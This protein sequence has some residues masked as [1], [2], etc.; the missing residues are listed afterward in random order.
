MIQDIKTLRVHYRR[1]DSNY[2]RWGLHLW[3]G[4]GIDTARLPA[5]RG[6]RQRGTRRCRS[7]P[8]RATPPTRTRSSSRCPCSTRRTT[9]PARTSAS[10]STAWGRRKPG[11]RRQGRPRRRHRHPLRH[12]DR[13]QPGRATCG[14]SRVM[15]R[16]TPA[17]PRLTQLNLTGRERRLA[18]PAADPVAGHRR[19]RPPSSCTTRRPGRSRP[20]RAWRSAARTVSL[21]LTAGGTVPAAA[22]ER[23][24]YVATGLRAVRGRRRPRQAA[25]PPHGPARGGGG[26]RRRQD[27]QRHRSC[28]PPARSTTC[29]RALPP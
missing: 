4:G 6:H 7:P 13:G 21:A 10:S 9:P 28:R 17:W 20:R 19:P 14:C 11:Q 12:T 16:S 29:T 5:G 15:P 26:N 8:S 1:T 27:P 3:N 18:E 22:A 24:A 2:A 25:R 23:F